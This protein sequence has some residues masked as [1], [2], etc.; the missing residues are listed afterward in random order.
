LDRINLD[1]IKKAVAAGDTKKAL[2]ELKKAVAAAGG[3]TQDPPTKTPP[4]KPSQPT[5]APTKAPPKKPSQPTKGPTK[6]PTKK[7]SQPTKGPLTQAQMDGI[8]KKHNDLRTGMGASD[9]TMMIWDDTLAAAAQQW[10][11]GTALLSGEDTDNMTAAKCPSGHSNNRQGAGENI[12]WKWAS[13]LKLTSTTDFS[14]SIQSWYDE[15]KDA[16]AYKS[17][18]TFNGFGPCTG[19]CG[20]YTQVVWGAANKIGCGA[21]YCPAHGMGGY[22]LVCQYGSSVAGAHGGNMG[23]STLFTKGTAC[24]KCPGGFTK[25]ANG[26]CSVGV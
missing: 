18:G 6:A 19:V 10:V 15:I 8:V 9:M 7:P 3:K 1:K 14:P 16:G 21:A 2:D 13:N 12:A 22:E 23:G 4:K 11:S 17:G 24:S 20:H 25:C 26:L 5:K